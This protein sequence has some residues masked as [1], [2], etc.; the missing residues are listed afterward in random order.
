MRAPDGT[1][2]PLSI[3]YRRGLV[4]DGTA[5]TLLFGYGAYGVSMPPAFL[6]GYKTWFE[7]GGVFA[8]A[9]VRGGGELG[10]TWHLAGKKATKPNSWRDFIACAEFLVRERHTAPAHL[11]GKGSSAGGM[12]MGRAITERPELFRAAIIGVGITN[13]LRFETTTNGVA[14]IP[15]FGSTATEAEFRGLLEMDAFH[16][17]APGTPYPPCS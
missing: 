7:Q 8:V 17:V 12:P 14:N 11:G 5:P 9:H 4:R 6:S 1:M 16:H 10:E 2:I 15:E 3:V 13:P